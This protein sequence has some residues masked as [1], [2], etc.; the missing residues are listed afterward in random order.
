MSSDLIEV[1]RPPY[2][3]MAEEIRLFL[4]QHDI[5]AVFA[6][7]NMGSMMP[8]LGTAI[9]VSVLVTNSDAV[10]A[11]Q[12]LEQREPPS[13][14]AGPWYCGHCRVDVEPGFEACWSCGQPRIDVEQPFPEGHA[15]P[16]TV[17][18]DEAIRKQKAEDLIRRAWRSCLILYGFVP[19]PIVGP[20]YSLMLLLESKG[21]GVQVSPESQRTFRRALTIDLAVLGAT[22]V[23]LGMFSVR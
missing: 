2:L 6:N 18:S 15:A 23:L 22:L 14:A 13:T 12:L 11:S 20:L 10:R 16:A 4:E 3:S 17:Q 8:H 19:L 5:K 7:E 1:A 21:L 9:G